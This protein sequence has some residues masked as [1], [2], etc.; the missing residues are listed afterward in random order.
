[1]KTMKRLLKK[2]G[3]P[4][5]ALLAYCSTLLEVGYTP[6]ELLMGRTLKTNVPIAESHCFGHFDHH[7]G[8]LFKLCGTPI[9]PLAEKRTNVLQ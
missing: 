4:Y 8:I 9:T 1:M 5:L 2:S 3:D 6:S 7:V